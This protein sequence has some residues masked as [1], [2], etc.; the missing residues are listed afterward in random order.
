MSNKNFFILWLASFAFWTAVAAHSTIYPIYMYEA[1]FDAAWIGFVTGA[2]ALG[3]LVVRPFVGWAVDRW[4]TRPFLLLGAG[5]WFLAS[6]LTA[7]TTNSTLLLLLRIVP[8]MGGGLFTAAALGY[9][10]Y[11]T[12]FERRGST[13]SWWDTSSSSGNL[14]APVGIVV[15]IATIG[16][17]GAFW[18]AGL[19][20]LVALILSLF[21]PH[22]VPGGPQAE[23]R[24]RFR[25]FS[26]SAL[27]PGVF[28]IVAGFSAG[29][30]IVLG[31]L[32][33]SLLG[34]KNV[35][36][37]VMLFSIGTLIVRPLTA[38]L[39]DNRGRAW[40]ILPGF[41]LMT[42]ALAFI[43]AVPGE[44][45]GYISPFVFGLGLGSAAPGLMAMCVDGSDLVERGTA[46][47]TY[48]VFWEIGIFAGAY[49][50][51][52]VLDAAGLPGFLLP[53]GLCLIAAG[54]FWYLFRQP[55]VVNAGGVVGD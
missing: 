12:P 43:G 21:L 4:G 55:R 46:G 17:S 10:G 48:F 34:L 51:G 2:A 40:V 8:G 27:L 35:G 33:G 25:M 28:T 41:M 26:R 31:P 42:V 54:V 44:W 18:A 47:N 5:M 49:F 3:G 20:A 53:A 23:T 38:P 7:L 39:S 50:Q 22:V 30:I 14:L 9:L 32:I 52:V 29:G 37:F 6:P 15:M 24:P 19:T 13:F 36:L 45:S 16:F 11:V 1:G